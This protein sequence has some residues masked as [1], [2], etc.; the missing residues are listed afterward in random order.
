MKTKGLISIAT[1]TLVGLLVLGTPTL[2]IAQGPRHPAGPQHP[3]AKSGEGEGKEHESPKTERGEERRE[4]FRGIARKLGTTPAALQSAFQAAKQAN[5]KLTMGQF[6]AANVIAHNLGPD[7]PAITTQA[8]LDGLKSGNSI[9]Q[10]LQ[11]LGLSKADAD[12]A[13]DAARK[14]ARVAEREA[15][16]AEKDANQD[17]S[18]PDKDQ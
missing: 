12:K 17:A 1:A 7:H 10:T 14:E 16:K 8:I 2:A 6:V 3:A 11:G 5:P 9:G 15:D 13:E 4:M 18:K